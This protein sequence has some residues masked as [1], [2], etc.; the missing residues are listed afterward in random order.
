MPKLWFKKPYKRGKM[1]NVCR[2]WMEHLPTVTPHQMSQ[3]IPPNIP[4]LFYDAH[5][6]TLHSPIHTSRPSCLGQF[7]R[8]KPQSL[9]GSL[10]QPI[11]LPG[12][13]PRKG[14]SGVR[15][16]GWLIVDYRYFRL[17]NPMYELP[18]GVRM[19]CVRLGHPR[20]QH[21]CLRLEPMNQ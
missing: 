6:L 9:W 12:S 2:L 20:L 10:A 21:V 16:R 5:Q 11:V 3:A 8:S 14:S 13:Y 7:A 19:S 18:G 15:G 4:H 17:S 1:R